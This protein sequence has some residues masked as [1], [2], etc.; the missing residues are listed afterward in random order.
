M[1][2]M[3]RAAVG[4][5]LLV[6]VTRLLPLD[7]AGDVTR[8]MAPVVLFLVAITVLAEL[9]EVAR[10]FDVA[11]GHAAR[12]ASGRTARLFLL[13]ALLAT[14]TTVLL[15]L[16]TTAVLLTPVVLSVAVQLD[17]PPMPFA[18]LTVWLANTA[19]LL[20]PVSNLTNLLA[21]DRL[22]LAP[23]QFAARMWAPAVV[24]VA[25]TVLLIGVRY[26]RLLR[27]RYA[28]PRR[29]T[30][31]D[32]V[33]LVASALACLGIVPALL[34]GGDPTWVVTVAV[35]LLVAV[36][37]VRRRAA[38]RFGLV[39]WR[40]AVFVLGLALTVE[41]VLRHGGDE[42]VSSVAGSGSGLADLGRVA[43]VGAVASNLLS[44]LPAYLILEPHA[45]GGGDTRL[46]ALLLGT[47]LGP[48]VL[49]WGSLATLLWRDRLRARG[50]DVS[51]RQF[52]AFGAYG[53]P[54][55]LLSS[56]VALWATS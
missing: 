17:L 35:V 25:L 43:G 14:A 23:H 7:V 18:L 49:L 56:V 4:A 6:L 45:A 44:N 48:M 39:P 1:A 53:V 19:S 32:A 54:V 12:L 36:F 20:L 22:G 52:A 13:V 50:L 55:V 28:V 24:A 16:D 29:P 42:A 51:W 2:A 30:I 40:L 9:A 47:N 15:G 34:L 46:L 10:L 8:R 41:A 37:A 38:L 3:W 33:L 21:L 26:R 27:V 31:D 11:A 5:A